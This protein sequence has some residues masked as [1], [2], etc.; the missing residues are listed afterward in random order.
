MNKKEKDF[1]DFEDGD[2]VYYGAEIY[3]L[4]VSDDRLYFIEGKNVD[5]QEIKP[6]SIET[7]G[8]KFD[9]KYIMMTPYLHTC[10]I[11]TN[12][13]APLTFRV[14]DN[15]KEILDQL[16]IKT[17]EIKY[18]HQIQKLIKNEGYIVVFKTK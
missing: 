12:H 5:P 9:I 8:D 10:I 7:D 16:S 13:T 2:F 15:I 1:F 4:R 17:K 6:V 14:R 11:K 3:D 18:I